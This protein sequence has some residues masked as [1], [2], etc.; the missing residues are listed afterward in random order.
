MIELWFIL[1]LVAA[2]LSSAS[3]I[4]ER[5]TLLKEHAMEFSSTL[6][7]IIL[8]LSI[9]MFFFI[10]Y[11]SLQLTPIIFFLSLLGAT[12]FFF[13]AKSIRHLG[14]GLS[15]PLF[16]LAP[17]VS[18]FLAFV[19]LKES[20]SSYQ[21]IGMSLVVTGAYAISTTKITLFAPFKH[22]R[23][24][25]YIFYAVGAFFLDGITSFFDRLILTKYSIEPLTF[26]ALA[27]IG[28]AFWAS[29]FI[30]KFHNGF[31]GV[32]RGIRNYGIWIFIIALLII[33]ARFAYINAVKIAYIGL[34]H[35][36]KH[37]AALI[38]VIVGGEI[39]HE[40]KLKKKIISTIIILAGIVLIT[41]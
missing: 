22:F 21:L 23:K 26:L 38:T 13:A 8:I 11:H 29:I 5:K 1:T 6:A 7:I 28:L 20:L 32:G 24:S 34:V 37:L 40:H 2:V 15:T 39:F 41:L 30:I 4:T 18:T 3:A 12:A 14:I 9:P 36:V 16:A 19:F 27:H 10:D 25:K 35:T 33:G 17:I 31:K